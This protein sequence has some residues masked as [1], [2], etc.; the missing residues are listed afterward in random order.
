MRVEDFDFVLPE[1]L[2]AL[3]PAHPRDAARM[4]VVQSDGTLEHAHVGDLPNYLRRGDILVVND[5]KVF[6]ARLQGKRTDRGASEPTI[7][8]MLHKRIAPNE[9][10]SFARPARKLADQMEYREMRA[11]FRNRAIAAA[12]SHCVWPK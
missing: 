12:G 7:E 4:L 9:F 2:I 8:I 6:P 5:T 1:E 3:R 11:G 10:L